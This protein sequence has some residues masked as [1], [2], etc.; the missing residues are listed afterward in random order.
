MNTRAR[1]NQ[2]V[3][4]LATPNHKW[5]SVATS[6]THCITAG[7]EPTPL[8]KEYISLWDA[9]QAVYIRND[10]FPHTS[11]NHPFERAVKKQ[12]TCEI[13][14]PKGLKLKPWLPFLPLGWLQ[15]QLPQLQ[16]S[17]NEKKVSRSSKCNLP[18]ESSTGAGI[19]QQNINKTNFAWSVSCS[20][21]LPLLSM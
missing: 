17:G 9:E 8:S 3:N 15:R 10:H 20:H 16:Q 19:L 1:G 13:P 18:R 4:N 7:W 2:F 11:T 21:N 12:L 5:W 14:I 6:L